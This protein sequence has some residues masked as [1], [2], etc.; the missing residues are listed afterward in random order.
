MSEPVTMKTY[1]DFVGEFVATM[2]NALQGDAVHAKRQKVIKTV[3]NANANEA[4]FALGGDNNVYLAAGLSLLHVDKPGRFELA[5]SELYSSDVLEATKRGLISGK[6]IESKRRSL[7]SPNELKML[8][9][10]LFPFATLFASNPTPPTPSPGDQPSSIGALARPEYSEANSLIF[11]IT[12]SVSTDQEPSKRAIDRGFEKLKDD[13]ERRTVMKQLALFFYELVKSSDTTVSGLLDVIMTSKKYK[14]DSGVSAQFPTGIVADDDARSVVHHAL[15]AGVCK[16]AAPTETRLAPSGG[17]DDLI[18]YALPTGIEDAIKFSQLITQSRN[19]EAIRASC[20]EIIAMHANA[21]HFGEIALIEATMALDGAHTLAEHA[22]ASGKC[23]PTSDKWRPC[24]KYSTNLASAAL[25]GHTIGRLR[26]VA[27]ADELAENTK[28]LLSHTAAVLK[29]DQ[30]DHMRIVNNAIVDEKAPTI[31]TGATLPVAPTRESNEDF[32]SSVH[33]YLRTL[34]ERTLYYAFVPATTDIQAGIDAALPN[35]SAEERRSGL[36]VELMR[37]LQISTDRVWIFIKTLSGLIGESAD[38]L[39]TT[40]DE[41]SQKAAKEIQAQQKQ[42]T[43]RVTQMQTRIVETLIA[44][45]LKDSNLQLSTGANAANSMVVV[46]GDT[47][48]QIR[49]LAAGES[50]RPFFEANVALRNLT[51]TTRPRKLGELVQEFNTVAE[52]LK[53]SLERELLPSADTAGATLGELAL[54]RNSYF[55]KLRDDTAAAIRAA[56]D[57]FDSERGIQGGIRHI[58][59]YEMVEGADPMLSSRFAEFAGH[60]L[61]QNRVSTGISA[62]Y[63]SRQQLTVNAAQARVSLVRLLNQA[64]HYASRFPTP[65]F[66][67][68]AHDAREA[69]FAKS[70]SVSSAD[71]LAWSSGVSSVHTQSAL[72]ST[73]GWNGGVWY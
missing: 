6:T 45:L 18:D 3:L 29:I 66:D 15:Q 28:Q 8:F 13:D 23:Q 72:V 12:S 51:D 41:A 2:G 5:P 44:G 33:D 17:I 10:A 71:T 38:A 25:L 24:G 14:Q 31:G 32:R 46:D 40:A 21:T 26:D 50:G 59:L 39:I 70:A 30:L 22:A 37:D 9:R 56:F 73:A 65:A 43:E 69:Y 60:L 62:I 7:D 27:A 34:V 35:G 55:V 20:S 49:D 58:F 57:R 16:Y 36:W 61:V 47:A 19:H 11:R 4:R 1:D 64:T 67:G 54:P 48:K 53:Q 52:T 63:A 68:N 42:I